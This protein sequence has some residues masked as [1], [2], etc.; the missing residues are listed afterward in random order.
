MT[1]TK[2]EEEK[3]EMNLCKLCRRLHKTPNYDIYIKES[4]I[5]EEAN[6]HKK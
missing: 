4:N 5:N 3:M 6:S 1:E 2:I